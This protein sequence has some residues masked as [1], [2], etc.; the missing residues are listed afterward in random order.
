MK[1]FPPARLVFLYRSMPVSLR[2]PYIS[3]YIQYSAFLNGCQY[4]TVTLLTATI[5]C[6]QPSQPSYNMMKQKFL[7]HNRMLF[8]SS[9][10]MPKSVEYFNR[11]RTEWG[12]KSV[13]P[14]PCVSQMSLK[15][16][17]LEYFSTSINL[18]DFYK[19]LHPFS[20][21]NGWK[22]NLGSVSLRFA[23]S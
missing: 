15:V 2:A 8:Y 21:Y 17:M 19:I 5:L 12:T 23:V 9:R 10:K 11:T 1:T 16:S 4:L 3:H 20:K 7:S 13:P 22:K 14:R 6:I 18:M